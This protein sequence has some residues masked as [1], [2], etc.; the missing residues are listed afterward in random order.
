MINTFITAFI[1]SHDHNIIYSTCAYLRHIFAFTWTFEKNSVGFIQII[2]WFKNKNQ[3]ILFF[4]FL[5]RFLSHPGS[6]LFCAVPWQQNQ[7]VA[8]N[9]QMMNQQGTFLSIIHFKEGNISI[10]K[11][12]KKH[13]SPRFSI[14]MGHR[15][16][17]F[18]HGPELTGTLSPSNG[19]NPESFPRKEKSTN[20]NGWCSQW[21]L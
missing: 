7:S 2:H 20:K 8:A 21:P 4:L 11:G 12:K 16:M 17:V 9:K 15:I 18:R 13:I 14:L 19:Q 5:N 1:L 10:L 3:G 6:F